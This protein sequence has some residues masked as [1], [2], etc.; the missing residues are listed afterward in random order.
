MKNKI[1]DKMRGKS[2]SLT[3]QNSTLLLT[4]HTI[5]G[6]FTITIPKIIKENNIELVDINGVIRSTHSYIF[7][8]KDKVAAKILTQA[9]Q[10]KKQTKITFQQQLPLQRR[11]QIIP[12]PIRGQQLQ[13]RKQIIPLPIQIQ[14]TKEL[15]GSSEQAKTVAEGVELSF[16]D[17]LLSVLFGDPEITGV[18]NGKLPAVNR[19]YRIAEGRD[20]N[21]TRY[22]VNTIQI[23]I[24]RMINDTLPLYSTSMNA[25]AI[26]H[27]VDIIDQ[28][29][30]KIQDPNKKLDY[31]VTK[32]DKYFDRGWSAMGLSESTLA[33]KNYLLKKDLRKYAPFGLKHHNPQRNLYQTLGMKGD[34]LPIIRTKSQQKLFDLGIERKGW[35]V[36][37]VFID[38]PLTFEDQIMIDKASWENR[39]YSLNKV[40]NIYAK[41][42]SK[43]FVKEG[44]E[45]EYGDV[46]G[47]SLD[48]HVVAVDMLG[49]KLIIDKIVIKNTAI[50]GALHKIYSINVKVIRNF[51][52]GFKLTNL[53]GN[54]GVC[55]LFENLATIKDPVHG[56]IKAEAVVSI[57]SVNKRKNFSQICEAVLSRCINKK[58]FII[59]DDAEFGIDSMR[60]ALRERGYTGDTPEKVE[61]EIPGYGTFNAIWGN[62]FWG[63]IKSP[64][65]QL[66]LPGETLEKNSKGFRKMG[67]KFSTVEVR[68]LV[69]SLGVNSKKTN[70]V[71]KE[72]MKWQQGADYIQ[73]KLLS[74]KHLKKK[75]AGFNR[76]KAEDIRCIDITKGL[77]LPE[78]SL[79]G[80][81]CD[82][83]LHPEGFI[84][85][86]PVPITLKISEDDDN[87]LVTIREIFIP[88]A[89]VRKYW[90]HSSG[91]FSLDNIGKALNFII[92]C[93]HHNRK[94][95]EV[96][97]YNYFNTLTRSLST[98][99]GELAQIGMGIRYPYSVKATATVSDILPKDTI[100]IHTTMAAQLE[101][102]DGSVV[103]VERFPCL[104][105]MSLRPQYIKVT[106]DEQCRYVIRV[107][108]NS[109]I[110][111]N[112]DFDGDVIYLAAFK[113][114]MANDYLRRL[115]MYENDSYTNSIITKMNDR[116]TP[117]ILDGSFDV[118]NVIAF[119]KLTKSEHS[120]IVKR[121]TGVKANTGPI[122]ALAYNLMRLVEGCIPLTKR[123]THADIEVLLDLLGNSVFSQKHGIK[124]LQEEAT[125]AIC[126]ANV[127]KMVELKFDEQ[128]SKILC[129]II[130]TEASRLLQ[131]NNLKA[132]HTNA[133]AKG[134]SNI[135]SLLIKTKHKLYFAS[136]SELLPYDL[137]TNIMY[138]SND[139]PSFL[140]KPYLLQLVTRKRCLSHKNILKLNKN[141]SIITYVNRKTKHI[142]KEIQN[143]NYK[144][145][146]S[147]SR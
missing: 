135:I 145:T 132:Y 4:L 52:E 33:D 91:L 142:Y 6:D 83:K 78:E 69:T 139:I 26:N 63:C 144:R 120:R 98:K 90:Q 59:K 80:T 2:Y 86:L 30:K 67:L 82:P 75:V 39:T 24:N 111:L 108:N 84:L 105:F 141:P 64:E 125:T 28:E 37:T 16:E 7:L 136:R 106:N 40:Y 42:E 66:W 12:L 131:I 107:S 102:K 94:R 146:A 53:A 128:S 77:M 3:E 103:L 49:E 93:V 11:K 41:D 133:K 117:C 65:D 129:N 1:H 138:D 23:F 17:F 71:I 124:S 92:Y 97:V 48:D 22:L 87:G 74:L 60:K 29:F 147:M 57:S 58:P 46:L 110:S 54:K 27:R 122:I 8:K 5:D 38:L 73:S 134:K 99:R 96:S 95:L 109:L 13:R 61:V 104:G 18:L 25:W 118:C 89:N 50:E 31:Q 51:K 116:K 68:A 130:K 36:P 137:Y 119:P 20:K 9:P 101:V 115:L 126:T 45:I 143:E 14:P 100:E 55:R 140:F 112:L 121:A 35:T 21:Y 81:I 47:Q 79:K 15:K 113:T 85:E 76:V 114:R 127:D 34:E 32:A 43:I 62:V 56:D 44:Q 123:K 88:Q 72:I 10:E 19:I 70:P